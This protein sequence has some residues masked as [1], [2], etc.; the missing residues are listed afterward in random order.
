MYQGIA[1]VT[2]ADFPAVAF[3]HWLHIASIVL[4]P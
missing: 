4:Q 3:L 2:K 1:I